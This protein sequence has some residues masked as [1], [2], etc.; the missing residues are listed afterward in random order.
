MTADDTITIPK[1]WVAAL[2]EALTEA[3]ES[4]ARETIKKGLR[5]RAQG[6]P[7][8]ALPEVGGS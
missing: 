7:L 2:I 8:V 3:A 4:E 6:A 5:W 1:T